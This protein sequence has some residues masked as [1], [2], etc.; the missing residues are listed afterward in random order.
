MD[1]QFIP[2]VK[3]Q[4]VNSVAQ[5]TFGPIAIVGSGNNGNGVQ[6]ILSTPNT[7]IAI[8]GT[9]KVAIELKTGTSL[10]VSEYQLVLNYDPQFLTVI[11]KDSATTGTQSTLVD[12]VFKVPEPIADNNYATQTSGTIFIKAT[13]SP[14]PINRQ[15]VEIEFQSQRIGATEIKLNEIPIQGTR[16]RRNNNDVPFNASSLNLQIGQTGSGCTSNAQCPSGQICLSNNTCGVAQTT[17]CTSN[18]QCP[19]GQEC[20]NGQCRN[21]ITGVTTTPAPRTVLPRTGLFDE[22]ALPFSILAFLFI[23]FGVY[24]RRAASARN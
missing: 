7:N 19:I 1:F 8:G 16:L 11:D 13:G 22:V 17:S 6:I 10:T 4:T 21:F 18:A 3:A 5:P 12:Q 23:M 24:L 14:V 20:V 15:V 2:T 9:F